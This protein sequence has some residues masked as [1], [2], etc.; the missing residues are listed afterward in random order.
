MALYSLICAD[1][2]LRNYSLTSC[3]YTANTVKT[4]TD[5]VTCWC[6][7]DSQL[8]AVTDVG[9]AIALRYITQRLSDIW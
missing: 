5:I 8:E 9:S 3:Y 2:P 6:V 1:V 7:L 4:T